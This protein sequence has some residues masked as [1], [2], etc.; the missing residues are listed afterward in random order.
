MAKRSTTPTV[1]LDADEEE[2]KSRQ[3]QRWT[4]EEEILLCECWVEVPENNQIGADRS[5][6][7]FWGQNTDDFNQGTYQGTHT[8]NMIT[9]KRSR[10]NGD[11]QKFN[12][13]YKHLQRKSGENKVDHINTAKSNFSA[14][15]K[16][17]KFFLE[18][19]WRVLKTHPKWDAPE[20]LDADGH[21]EL[22]DRD[23]RP[24]PAVKP[25]PAKK[26]KSETTESTGEVI[27]GLCQSFY[28]RIKDAKCN[29]PRLHTRQRKGKN[30]HT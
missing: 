10:I 26:T 9:S 23:E 21:T 8:K 30:W 16:G 18:H 11:Y 1:D 19:A 15:S 17:R 29:Q 5:E 28:M 20:P 24:R 3:M 25:R 6:D 13:I 7:S 22:F 4:R 12:A 27:Q 14:Q 2:E